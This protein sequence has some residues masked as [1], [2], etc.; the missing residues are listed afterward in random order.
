V[1][2]KLETNSVENI[3]SLILQ[4]HTPTP[5]LIIEIEQSYEGRGRWQTK[6]FN[7]N[8]VGGGGLFFFFQ[9]IE[10]FSMEKRPKFTIFQ[11]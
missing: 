6:C 2:K 8:F 5:G 11:D 10:G 1:I 3:H 4:L 7:S 9:H